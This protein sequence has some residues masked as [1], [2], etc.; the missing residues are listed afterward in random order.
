M[1]PRSNQENSQEQELEKKVLSLLSSNNEIA[2]SLDVS[3]EAGVSH[4]DLDKVL[5]S[6]LVDDYVTLN[7]LEKKF[8]QLT[9]EGKGYAEKGTPEYQYAAA[10]E[11]GKE[12]PKAT[13]EQLIGDKL[14]KIGFGKA[15]QKKWIQVGGEKKDLVTRT[16]ADLLDQDKDLLCKFLSASPLESHD[17]KVVDQLKKR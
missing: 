17:K 13:V 2:D 16:A 10:L 5:K 8:V 3:K 4:L 11:V 7:V 9:A 12:T 14:A 6:L 15:M 1:E